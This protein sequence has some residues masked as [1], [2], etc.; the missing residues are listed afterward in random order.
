MFHVRARVPK[1]FSTREFSFRGEEI[2][3]DDGDVG[4]LDELQSSA[5]MLE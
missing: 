2:W 1:T 4:P 5:V 3:G